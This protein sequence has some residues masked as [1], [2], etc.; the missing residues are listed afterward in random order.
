MTEMQQN[1]SKINKAISREYERLFSASD[2]FWEKKKASKIHHAITTIKF[3]MLVIEQDKGDI[4]TTI[5]TVKNSFFPFPYAE[6]ATD[7]YQ[8]LRSTQFK[9]ENLSSIDKILDFKLEFNDG[10]SWRKHLSIKEAL[11]ISRLNPFSAL[12][13][14]YFGALWGKTA[15]LSK[16]EGKLSAIL[17]EELVT[18][19]T[20]DKPPDRVDDSITPP[21]DHTKFKR[22]AIT[23]VDRM[24]IHYDQI[25][26]SR[27]VTVRP[28]ERTQFWYR[29]CKEFRDNLKAPIQIP[30][31]I[32]SINIMSFAAII[33]NIFQLMLNLGVGNFYDARNNAFGIINCMAHAAYTSVKG[34]LDTALSLIQIPTCS[35]FTLKKWLGFHVN[36]EMGFV[37]NTS[38]SLPPENLILTLGV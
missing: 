15:A 23:T 24:K 3:V 12:F 14:P 36:E 33:E 1:L 22:M 10:V 4:E 6:F 31:I 9:Q 21:R 20:C 26:E 11:N 38:R 2:Y 16:F 13:W 17:L 18:S 29:D 35:Y 8:Y 32:L 37:L 34:I 28:V 25:L 30:L 7:E 19:L 27:G 5:K